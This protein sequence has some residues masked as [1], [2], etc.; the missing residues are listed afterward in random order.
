MALMYGV[1]TEFEGGL[2]EPQQN[3]TVSE[4]LAISAT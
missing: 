2:G 1:G 3:G 4:L